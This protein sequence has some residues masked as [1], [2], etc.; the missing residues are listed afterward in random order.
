M[1]ILR[2]L[3]LALVALAVPVMRGAAQTCQGMS[4]FQDGT[5][6]VGAA[7]QHNSDFNAFMG[8]VAYGVPRSWYAGVDFVDSHLSDSSPSAIGKTSVGASVYAGYQIHLS[9]TP[10]QV[11]PSVMWQG[12][13]TTNQH[14]SAIGLGGTLGY[15]VEIS[16]WF[17]LVPAAGVRWMSTN[18]TET[19]ILNTPGT[20]TTSSS[21][22]QTNTDVTMELG[23]VFNKTFT[24]VP[25]ILIPSQSGAKSIYTIGVSINWANAIPR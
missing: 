13:S 17:A 25:G 20:G 21:E 14:A 3:A 10:F 19:G 4:A 18:T 16:D 12:S 15:R 2:S 8:G 6:R 22:T 7:D 11:C 23:L 1:R 9:D 5:W 24:I